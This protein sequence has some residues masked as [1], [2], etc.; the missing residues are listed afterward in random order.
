MYFL[1][2]FLND[3]FY[4]KKDSS[5]YNYAD[6]NT[7]DYAGYNI[8]KLIATLENDSFILIDWFTVNQMKA[9]PDKFQAIPIGNKSH[10]EH[11]SFNLKGKI[12]KCEDEVK[13]LGVT[14]DFQ[15]K[16][17]THIANTC[18]KAS[19]QL[20]VL[21]RV[22]KYLNSLGKLTIYH[23]FILSNF[24]Y[25]PVTWHFCNPQN[26]KRWKRY[27]NEQYNLY[28]KIKIA[29]MSNS[30]KNLNYRH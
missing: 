18:K 11:I 27:R 26:T 10:S 24:N 3:I 22:G 25:C 6:D 4:L 19:R 21:K 28:M 9:N 5:L 20:N 2:F 7:L 12:I 29:H 14:I 8:E 1:N 16:F 17:N 13:L 23:S 15:L 30:W